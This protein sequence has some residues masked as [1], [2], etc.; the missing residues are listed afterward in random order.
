M[1]LVNMTEWRWPKQVVEF[2]QNRQ[3][4]FVWTWLK[5]DN[6]EHSLCENDPAVV[7]Y[8]FGQV[9]NPPVCDCYD[10]NKTFSCL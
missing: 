5:T 1:R 6:D 8:S 7:A 2:D 4:S 9:N 3:T 10:L